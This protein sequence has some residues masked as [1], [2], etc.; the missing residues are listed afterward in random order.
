MPQ[1]PLDVLHDVAKSSNDT[2]LKRDHNDRRWSITK[3]GQ[4][5]QAAAQQDAVAEEEEEA[6]ELIDSNA[7]VVLINDAHHDIDND[8]VVRTLRQ[9]SHLRSEDDLEVVR[10]LTSGIKF[11]RQLNDASLH[12]ELCRH[13]TFE[14]VNKNQLIFQQGDEGTTF[15][16]IYSGAIKVLVLD[17]RTGFG[18]ATGFGSNV[19]V[20]EDGDS[21][22]EL[23]LLGNGLRA[24][25][26]VAAMPTLLLRIEKAAYDNS[27]HR[28][29][30]AE[31]RE[32]IRFL[33]RIFLFS[34]WADEDL[35]R[36]AKVVTR[37]RCTKN[38]CIIQQHTN[39]DHMYLIVSG[40]CRVLKRMELSSSLQSKLAA[41][42]G[43]GTGLHA[44][45]RPAPSPRAPT[46]RA[47]TSA[48]AP[49]T[50]RAMT[51]PRS[52][53]PRTPGGAAPS[54]S[55]DDA[56]APM[57]ELGELTVHQ[58]FG[59]RALL[60][61]K[62]RGEKGAHTA[63]VVSITPVELLLLSKYDFYHCIDAKTQ[64]LM[65]TYAEKFYFDEERIR[66]SIH[67]QFRW[68][69]YKQGLLKDVLSPRASPRGGGTPRGAG[70][71]GL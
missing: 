64:N 34:D 23:A 60:Q 21:F 69:T 24:A 5:Q 8:P 44:E 27:L 71:D 67:K 41:Q 1:Q 29:H 7:T 66:R 20:L 56:A 10:R 14:E 30:E 48:R 15:Y 33:Q 70:G 11:F 3:A 62:Q 53:S 13:I 9:P 4:A 43:H 63:S 55:I 37:K 38:E 68:D 52:S 2:P 61:G 19:C 50:P 59:E 54:D 36:L 26:V 40:R 25:T 57:L 47:Q 49:A 28:L 46:P 58:Y 12:L 51:S 18:G 17:A 45:E 22:G 65:V 35:Q 16:V 31:L 39:T 32:R 42:R 6:L